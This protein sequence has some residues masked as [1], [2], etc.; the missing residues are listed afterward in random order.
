MPVYTLDIYEGW[1]QERLKQRCLE[2]CRA[3]DEWQRIAMTVAEHGA[4][5]LPDDDRFRLERLIKAYQD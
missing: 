2:L 3:V 1:S 4:A 5:G